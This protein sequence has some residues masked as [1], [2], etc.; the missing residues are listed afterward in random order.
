MKEKLVDFLKTEIKNSRVLD[1]LEI[2]KDTKNGDFSL[3][4]FILSKEMKKSP[5]EIAKELE[6]KLNKKKPDFVDKIIAVG[7]FLNFFVDKSIISKSVI[8]GISKG[9]LFKVKSSSKEK[10]LIEYPSPNT[11]KSLHIGHVRNILLGNTL[12]KLLSE[13]GHRV[14]RTNLNNDRG[15]AVCKAMLAYDLYGEN[16]TPKDLGLKPDKF[17]EH[18]YVM[19]GEKAKNDSTLENKALK[20][21]EKWES[22]DKKTIELWKKLLKWV[23]EGY[24]ETYSTLKLEKFDKE[25]NESEIYD[26]GK[27]LVL[28]ALK[29]NV[30]GFVKEE[31]GAVLCDFKDK[32]YGKKYLLR[33]NGTTL[34]MTQDLYLAS[35]KA[36]EF[37]CDKYIFVVGKEQEY[38]F[39]VLFKLLD[40]MKITKSNN[41]VHFSYGY[42]YD[43]DGNKF[44][45]RKGN[46]LRA[47]ELFSLILEK[48]ISNLKSKELT[49]NLSD[50]EIEKRARVISFN[51][52]AFT[53]LKVNP[54]NDIKFDVDKALAFEGES[55]PYV[56]YTYARIKSIL[57]KAKF[58]KINKIDSS[59]F[60][61]D[62][63]EMFSMLNEYQSIVL[64]SAD[65][66]KMSHLASYLIRVS[67]KFNEYYQKVSILKEDNKDIMDARLVMCYCVS[68]VLKNGLRILDMQ[69]LEEM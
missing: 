22:G 68:E 63:N 9:N 69:T 7:P 37:K 2:P 50:R 67:K 28:G 20:M 26:K 40:R 60:S 12:S 32:T 45:S 48:A 18:F 19:F 10:V 47:D 5:A 34:Y 65:K 36:K 35:V 4:V 41:N 42:V 30:E 21:L 23:H 57:R 46:V 3:P 8:E 64:E 31:D 56:M 49:K 16:K 52:L 43:K 39:E 58:E 59:L 6:G 14:I 62:E 33:G 1:L 24:K 25:F 15:I 17:V 44:S 66:Y 51:A 61:S 54:T 53:M 13:V 38:H 55:G 11:N 27:E 29:N